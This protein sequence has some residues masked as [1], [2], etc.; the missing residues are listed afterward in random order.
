MVTAA[1]AIE[2]SHGTRAAVTG[3]LL[4]WPTGSASTSQ[5]HLLLNCKA[6]STNLD[7]GKDAMPHALVFQNQDCNHLFL[8]IDAPLGP[9]FVNITHIFTASTIHVQEMEIILS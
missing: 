1:I 9:Q 2:Q 8:E 3:E 7:K 6:F 5:E 4:C